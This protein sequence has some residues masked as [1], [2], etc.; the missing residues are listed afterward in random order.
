MNTTETGISLA[1][2]FWSEARIIEG[3]MRGTYVVQG[4]YQV[5]EAIRR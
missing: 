5:A 1:R 2:A 3:W 4:E